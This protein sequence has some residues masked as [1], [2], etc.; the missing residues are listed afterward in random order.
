METLTAK[1]AK[2]ARAINN[3]RANY[4]LALIF[5]NALKFAKIKDA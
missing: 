2:A 4:V 1:I 5:A 3:K